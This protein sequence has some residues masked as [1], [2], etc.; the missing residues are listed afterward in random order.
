MKK[1][2]SIVLAIALVL[3]LSA[4]T[5][6]AAD[7]PYNGEVAGVLEQTGDYTFAGTLTGAYT[8]NISGTADSED[9]NYTYFHGTVTGDIEGN[10]VNGVINSNG[11][12]TVYAK[13]TDITGYTGDDDVWIVGVFQQSGIDNDF[14]GDVITGTLPAEVTTLTIGTESGD[15]EVGIGR[16]LQM[17]ATTDPE[18]DYDINWGIYVNDRSKATIDQDGVVTGLQTG[19]VTVIATSEDPSLATDTFVVT[20]VDPETEV[21]AD[22]RRDVYGRDHADRRLWYDLQEHGHSD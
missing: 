7:P 21:T 4:V 13:I 11:L 19:T 15:T 17:T 12:D 10:L 14:V 2:I 18:G 6:L 3:G 5:A 16:T 1:L 20:V 22:A 8:L 9:G